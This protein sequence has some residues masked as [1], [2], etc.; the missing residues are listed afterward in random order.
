M[1]V[2]F[3]MD[4]SFDTPIWRIR[5]LLSSDLITSL[6][7][8]LF[9]S[10]SSTYISAG[11][12]KKLSLEHKTPLGLTLFNMDPVQQFASTLLTPS[13][14]LDI[15]KCLKLSDSPYKSYLSNE[16]ACLMPF[17]SPK[18]CCNESAPSIIL[19]FS[20]FGYITPFQLQFVY[21]F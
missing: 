10:D 3:E 6:R 15:A 18:V 1:V 9:F 16:S 2:S 20:L 13:F 17:Y 11:I 14:L 8:L 5:N 21:L 19:S 7:N 4:T 12:G